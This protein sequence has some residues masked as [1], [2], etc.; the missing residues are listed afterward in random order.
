MKK[1]THTPAAP[2]A[3][4]AVFAAIGASIV[5]ATSAAAADAMLVEAR[6]NDSANLKFW[7]NGT[8]GPDGSG[9][10]GKAGDKSYDGSATKNWK[11][12][13]KGPV[14]NVTDAAEIKDVDA[15]TFTAWYKMNGAARGVM[16]LFNSNLGTLLWDEGR[17]LWVFR[18][19]APPVDPGQKAP[20]WFSAGRSPYKSWVKKDEWVFLAITWTR[21]TSTMSFYQGSKTEVV[22]LGR[23]DKRKDEARAITATTR[24]LT[25]VGNT[26][27]KSDRPVDASIDN[28]RVYPKVLTAGQIETVR[29]ADMENVNPGI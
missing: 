17:S 18:N 24:R 8:L 22:K 25:L 3:L 1:S 20:Y 16:T 15:F 9:V 23:D 21:A 11:V 29:K 2:R 19:S 5:F 7:N 12:G 27:G 14:A 6:F 26:P 4:R 10:S 28:V 13:E